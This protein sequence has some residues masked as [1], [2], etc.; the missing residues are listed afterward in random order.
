MGGGGGA[1][2]IST[3]R[4]KLG[5]LQD[6]PPPPPHPPSGESFSSTEFAVDTVTV[7]VYPVCNVESKGAGSI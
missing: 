3:I 1:E 7:T 6:S 4:T 5:A 2:H